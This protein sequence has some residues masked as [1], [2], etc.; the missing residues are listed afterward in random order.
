MTGTD[1]F[2]RGMGKVAIRELKHAGYIRLE[3]FAGVAETD[4]LKLHGVGPKALG[5]LRAALAER[6]LSFKS[7]VAP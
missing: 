6:G 4:L 3:Q 5:V 1:D 2:P 7:K